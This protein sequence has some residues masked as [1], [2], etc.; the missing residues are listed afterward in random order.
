MALPLPNLDDKTFAQLA[1]EARALIPSVAPAWTDHNVHDPGITFL[2]LF[3]WLA[4]FDHYRLNRTSAASY[5]RF[6][7]L[8]G[9]TRRGHQTAEVEVETVFDK[10][11]KGV[12]VPAHTDLVSVGN[13]S[14]PFQTLRDVYLTAAELKEIVTHAGGRVIEQTKA[15]VNL[16]GHYEA[17]GAAPAVGDALELGFAGWF[18]EEEG[19]LAITLFE[20]DLPPRPPFAPDVAGFVPS[21]KVRWEYRTSSGWSELSVIE[22]GTLDFSRS[23]WLHFRKPE[24]QPEGRAAPDTNEALNWMR[25]VIV[26]GHF[27]IPPRLFSI[28]LNT[29]RARQVELIVNEDLKEGLGT[30]DQELRLRK[31]PV[32]L[33]ETVAD[34]PFQAG[35]V[36]D[37]RALVTR[38]AQ[39][40]ELRDAQL[41]KAVAHVAERLKSLG[42]VLKPL[43]PGELPSGDE[44][45]RLAGFFNQLLEAEDFYQRDTLAVVV[46][47]AEFAALKTEAQAT[48]ST[49]K[50][51]RRF[52]RFLLQ[53]IFPDLLL[54]DRIEIQTSL[55][56]SE[57]LEFQTSMGTQLCGKEEVD[58]WR[59]WQRV[60]D[61]RQSGPD[62]RH[63]TLEAQTGRLQFGNGLNGLIP[64][65]TE[66]IRARFYRVSLGA[67]GNLSAEKFWQLAVPVEL[68]SEDES[69]PKVWKNLAPASGGQAPETL[70]EA[71]LR[72]RA[73]FRTKS[74]VLTASDYE[75]AALHTPGLRVAR[76]QVVANFNPQLPK[77]SMPG[78]LTIIVVPQPA[79]AVAFPKAGPPVPSTGFLNTVRNYLETL[80]LVTTNLHVLG[81]QYVAVSVSCRVFL[82]KGV[83]QE[84]VL[85][86][87][88]KTLND[89]LDPIHGGP[90]RNTGWPFARSVFPSEVH[91]QL[92][93]IAGVDYVTD[94]ALRGE[95][96]GRRL[97][98][99]TGEPQLRLPYNGLPTAGEHQVKL[100]AFEERR[101]RTARGDAAC[102]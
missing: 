22:D 42:A 92:A 98:P 26:D 77:L 4:E 64:Q 69:T 12:F 18:T 73:V 95:L 21:A 19:H 27:E 53:R 61:F 58:R 14:I 97:A 39:A 48:C 50:Q 70:D 6:F 96:N 37:W 54:S 41:A 7:S 71:K 62:D 57:R 89:Y 20:D 46:A 24:Q 23:G 67:Q 52:N 102:E 88:K 75:T 3:A 63:Y 68:P 38:L 51:M 40:G 55:P 60:A 25:A 100:V 82:K 9:L 43:K 99:R 1:F 90:E 11:A 76:A 87:I 13:E 16:A 33:D 36:L 31:A 17:F 79:P 65:K 66:T 32:L 45:H 35:E 15:E 81:P 85:R 83:A 8:I 94:V 84:V 29:L 2:E 56:V 59:L 78:E 91:Q 28:V 47:T 44:Q 30:P 93:R 74:P 10:L 80:R 49:K 34:G 86:T 5:A 72:A 101:L